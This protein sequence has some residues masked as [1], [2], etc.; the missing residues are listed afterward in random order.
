MAS[1]QTTAALLREVERL[2]KHLDKAVRLLQEFA[3]LKPTGTWGWI[4]IDKYHRT[5]RKSEA[6]L[7]RLNGGD[8]K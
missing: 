1:D 5:Q 4:D 8:I 3:A 2:Q 6:L 7:A